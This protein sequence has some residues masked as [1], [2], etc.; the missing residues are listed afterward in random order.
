MKHVSYLSLAA[1]WIIMFINM[2]KLRNPEREIFIPLFLRKEIKTSES[3]KEIKTRK[4]ER[5]LK[6]ENQ[7]GN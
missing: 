1:F 6:Q 3:E 2:W 4:S 5:K 7:K